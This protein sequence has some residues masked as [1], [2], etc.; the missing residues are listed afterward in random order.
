M[1]MKYTIKNIALIAVIIIFILVSATLS[2]LL[3]TKDSRKLEITIDRVLKSTEDEDWI[4]AKKEIE[5]L[6]EE[7]HSV[8]RLWS[9]LIDHN[10]IDNIDVTLLRLKSLIHSKDKSTALSEATALKKYIV[11]IPEKEKL[12]ISNLF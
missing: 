3:L 10:E 5:N 7:W 2:Q 8:M 12:N 6:N 11:H 9:A 1:K 4:K